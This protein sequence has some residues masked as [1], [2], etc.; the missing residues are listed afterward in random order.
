MIWFTNSTQ[1]S[2]S[3]DTLHY[4]CHNPFILLS[5]LFHIHIPVWPNWSSCG[6]WAAVLTLVSWLV[7]WR[8]YQYC[9]FTLIHAPGSRAFALGLLCLASNCKSP[10]LSWL[11]DNSDLFN[12]GLAKTGLEFT[13]HPFYINALFLLH[14]AVLLLGVTISQLHFGASWAFHWRLCLF[15][16]VPSIFFCLCIIPAA[17]AERYQI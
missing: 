11:V 13:P 15:V 12:N 9:H 8:A 4:S 14:G 16:R 7:G 6:V 10:C 2:V 1:K 17:K 3:S 5:N